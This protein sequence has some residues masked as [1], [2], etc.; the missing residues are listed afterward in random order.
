MACVY[1]FG[2]VMIWQLPFVTFEFANDLRRGSALAVA[3]YNFPPSFIQPRVY[4]LIKG[5]IDSKGF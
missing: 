5:D 4:D 1:G 3:G 2:L